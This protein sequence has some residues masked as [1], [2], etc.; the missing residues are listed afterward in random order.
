MEIHE[1]LVLQKENGIEIWHENELFAIFEYFNQ[2][3]RLVYYIDSDEPTD[4]L[5]LKVIKPGCS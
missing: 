1:L 2:C 3:L 4:S 5:T